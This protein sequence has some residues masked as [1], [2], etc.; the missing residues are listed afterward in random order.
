MIAAE[1]W[2]TP[3]LC[4]MW[5]S[6]GLA[7]AGFDSANTSIWRITERTKVLVTVAHTRRPGSPFPGPGGPGG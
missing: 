6:R 1:P 3:V 2:V 7:V 5:F 4:A